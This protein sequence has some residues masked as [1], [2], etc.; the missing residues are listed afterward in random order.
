[1]NISNIEL[2]RIISLEAEIIKIL[3]QKNNWI[4]IVSSPV[5]VHFD[6][7]QTSPNKCILRLITYN[8]LHNTAFILHQVEFAASYT[9][10]K[11]EAL[12]KMLIYIKRDAKP[13]ELLSY[14]VKWFN[15]Q[16]IDKVIQS[17]FYGYSIID[18]CEKFY[19]DKNKLDY[20]ITNI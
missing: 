2:N 3:N 6:Y 12:N 11:A 5:T 16:N 8:S 13:Q 14:T 19:F 9:S 17:Y 10:V 7:E 1:M 15:K 18:V 20:V 4:N